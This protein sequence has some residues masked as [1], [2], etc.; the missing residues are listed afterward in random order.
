MI[1]AEEYREMPERKRS[2]LTVSLVFFSSTFL[3]WN[4]Q[5]ERERVKEI[6]DWKE[7]IL[8]RNL[9]EW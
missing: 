3:S 1:R 9:R 7:G 4:L 2:P 6:G 5:G 8:I